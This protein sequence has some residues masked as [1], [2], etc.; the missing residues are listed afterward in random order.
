MS[1]VSVEWKSFNAKL[2]I[3]LKNIYIHE[4]ITCYKFFFEKYF[5]WE[6]K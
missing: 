4:I 5:R 1:S 2:N 6:F 3:I